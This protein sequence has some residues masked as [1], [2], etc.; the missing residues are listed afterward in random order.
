[1]YELIRVTQ[2]VRIWKF[3]WEQTLCS[4]KGGQKKQNKKYNVN[5]G[6]VP[7]RKKLATESMLKSRSLFTGFYKS[8]KESN[9]AFLVYIQTS[10]MLAIAKSKPLWNRSKIFAGRSKGGLTLEGISIHFGLGIFKKMYEIY[11]L[12]MELKWTL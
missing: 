7:L 2:N 5:F 6:F 12:G 10:P 3:I 4:L 8:C 9:Y 1:M 11:Y